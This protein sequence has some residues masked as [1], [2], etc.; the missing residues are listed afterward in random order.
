MK[1]NC[2]REISW[3][4]EMIKVELPAHIVE[5][6]IL[7]HEYEV[8]INVREGRCFVMHLHKNGLSSHLPVHTVALRRGHRGRDAKP[9]EGAHS[10]RPH[11][12]GCI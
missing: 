2:I 6:G 3:I 1:M 4:H 7:D 11:T 8:P 10:R 12:T 5:Q 9:V